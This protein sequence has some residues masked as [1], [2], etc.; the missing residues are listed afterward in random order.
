M[1]SLQKNK[2]LEDL[3]S[4]INEFKNS[5]TSKSSFI[6]ELNSI[7]KQGLNFDDN[8]STF[9]KHFNNV[10]PDFFKTLNSE[11]PSLTNNDLKACAYMRMNLST[12]EV[13]TL[14]NVTPKSVKMSRYRLKKKLNL[15]KDDDLKNFLFE[16]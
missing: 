7:V 6:K 10:H 2:L 13:S 15:G 14:T 16:L 8:W 1:S 3:D 11:F 4:K 5:E 12:K 9:Q